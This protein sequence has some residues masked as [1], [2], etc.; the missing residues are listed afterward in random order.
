MSYTATL[1]VLV[2]AQG[3]RERNAAADL[4]VGFFLARVPDPALFQ[5]SGR[6]LSEARRAVG[7]QGKRAD[8]RSGLKKLVMIVVGVGILG[9]VA[10]ATI[11]PTSARSSSATSS[12]STAH[13]L[14]LL[15]L[16]SA[17]FILALTLAQA[18]MAL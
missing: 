13:D 16:G 6:A 5:R 12:T 11:G 4:I 17:A 2:L 18:L 8:F 14:T 7:A 3:P 10:G 1:G 9:V 15:F